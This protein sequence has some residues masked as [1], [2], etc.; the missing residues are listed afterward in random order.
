M[1]DLTK[2][3]AAEIAQSLTR[4][5]ARYGDIRGRNLALDM[6]RGKPSAAQLDLS[7][8]L[9]TNIGPGDVIDTDGT[10]LRNYGGLA[11]IPSCRKLFGDYL[12]V[13]AEQ[14][15]I[16]GNSSLQMMYGALARAMTF[17]VVGGKGPWR[18][19]APVVICPV[20]GY[21]RHFAI[22]EELGLTMV[23]VDM[24]DDGPDMDAVEELVANDPKVKAI[25]CVPKYSNPTGA[26]Y[27]DAVVDR[28]AKMKAAAPDF[29]ILWDNA[30]AV[31]HLGRGLD[32]VADILAACEA[33]GCPDRPFIFGSTSKIT[34]AGA[35]IAMFA[36]SKANVKDALDHLFFETIGPDKITQLRQVKFFGDM[37]GVLAHMDAHAELVAPKF[38]AV[39]D[40]LTKHLAGKGI[41]TWT[42][43]RGG[44]FV[45]LDVLDGCAKEVIR[46]AN[47]AGVKLT[48]AGSC[49]PYGKDPFDRNI[50]LAPT[51]PPLDEVVQAMEVVCACVELA[52]LDKLAADAG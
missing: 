4:A 16:G 30:Y 10:D 51:L 32:T 8:G 3:G 28:L 37:D 49:F 5:K 46:L 17:G 2:A 26:T 23:N 50:R 20:P 47:E 18:D 45:S 9:L 42:K 52:C 41:A 12:G 44:Y 19:E 25:W 22:C 39:D 33:A 1:I 36:G 7:D 24:K 34:Y 35:G 40:A 29:R 43:P 21:D 38:K 31:H 15:V 11:G 48:P 13:P 6:T 27:S 14:V